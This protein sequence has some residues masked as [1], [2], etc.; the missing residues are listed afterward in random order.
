VGQSFGGQ[1]RYASS[2]SIR[3]LKVFWPARDAVAGLTADSVSFVDH[4]CILRSR[5]SV[6]FGGYEGVSICMYVCMYIR[7]RILCPALLTLMLV[8]FLRWLF[9]IGSLIVSDV[10]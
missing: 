5:A 9:L 8:R 10:G 6:F 2:V 7:R 4:Y 3:R 1:R